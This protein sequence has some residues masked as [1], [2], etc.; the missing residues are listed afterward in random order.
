M[1]CPS[2]QEAL[3]ERR[4]DALLID[5]CVGCGGLWFDR[6]KIRT[7]LSDTLD[8]HGKPGVLA[9]IRTVRPTP[10]NLKCPVC[11][12]TWLKSIKPYGVEVEQCPQC[13]GVFLERGEIEAVAERAVADPEDLEAV[14]HMS[15][16]P[17]P[18]E[19]RRSGADDAPGVAG[20]LF[21]LVIGLI[22]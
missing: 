9:A 2:C 15:L 10:T 5:C 14:A 22:L 19:A 13:L 21:E 11:R 7:H 3:V 1:I 8:A 16:I 12:H 18:V 20:T 6:E 17:P 4:V